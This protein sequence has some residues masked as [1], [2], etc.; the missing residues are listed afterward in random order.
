[1]I[2]PD[3][4]HPIFSPPSTSITPQ[5]AR[6]GT[7]IIFQELLPYPQAW[8]LQQR[9]HAERVSGTRA[10]TLVLL[11]HPPVYT[12]GR[13][14]QSDHLGRGE[15]ALRETGASIEPVNRGGSVTYHGPGQLVGY[16]ILTLSHYASGP[17]AYV[18]LLEEV[19]IQT[20]ALSGIIGHRMA[21]KPGVWATTNR[22]MAK[23]ASIGVR[24]EHGVTLH[25]FALNVNVDLSPFALIVPCGLEGCETTSMAEIMRAPASLPLVV[26]QIA[27]LFSS[28]FQLEWKSF[29]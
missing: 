6:P 2:A 23:I 7:L 3:Q 4:A 24:V 14:T 22:G 17:K 29:A 27:D 25:G 11:E 1:V 26:R 12:V 18:Q 8:A 9:F 20:V 19:L 13:R 5:S 15:D 28:V 21:H 16:P 10:D